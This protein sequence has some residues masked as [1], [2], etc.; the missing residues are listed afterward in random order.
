MTLSPNEL[1]DYLSRLLVTLRDATHSAI[2]ASEETVTRLS[3][4]LN[5]EASAKI[6]EL[7]SSLA[8]MQG[9]VDKAVSET[10]RIQELYN[11]LQEDFDQQKVSL[12][13]AAELNEAE[14]QRSTKTMRELQELKKAHEKLRSQ[15]EDERRASKKDRELI[16]TL[17]NEVESL[18]RSTGKHQISHLTCI[19]V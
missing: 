2:Q 18:K 19:C 16:K 9:E 11:G 15:Y 13:E 6:S 7:E 5:A 17:Q 3:S 4:T 14:E 10:R 12:A 1:L 8:S